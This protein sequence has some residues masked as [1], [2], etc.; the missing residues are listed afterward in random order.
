VQSSSRKKLQ[1]FLAGW[2]LRLDTLPSRKVR[3]A[4][5]VDPLEF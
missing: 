4:L 2:R 3:W 1:T 5:D